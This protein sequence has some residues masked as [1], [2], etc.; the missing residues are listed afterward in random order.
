MG[1]PLPGI[2]AAIVKRTLDGGVAVID[3]P[4][5]DGELALR[6]GWPSMF[7]AYLHEEQRYKKCFA[8]GFYLSGDL[9]RRDADGYSG[10]SA[11]ATTS[12]RRRGTSSAPSRSRARCWSTPRSPRRG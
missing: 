3:A 6:P 5:T 10:S 9:A 2:A 4:N 12:S 7:R 1:K 11:G 8:D